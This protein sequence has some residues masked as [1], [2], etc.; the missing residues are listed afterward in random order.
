MYDEEE[1]R[2]MV[3]IAG[4]EALKTGLVAR[5]WGNISARI[6]KDEFVITP[7]GR[8]YEDLSPSDLVKVR[9]D[10][11]SY[12]GADK[13]SSEKG[14]H[15]ACYKLRG[16]VDFV[17]HTHQ[18]YA[19]AVGVT[20]KSIRKPLIPCAAY[21]MPSTKKLRNN[22]AKVVARY[23]DCNAFLM[24]KHGALCLGRTYEEAFATAGRL[25][26]VC[27]RRYFAK[28]DRTL[29]NTL[30]YRP[31]GDII[32]A[33]EGNEVILV[34]SLGRTLHPAI[35]DL[36]QITGLS[37][38]CVLPEA[39]EAEKQKALR[40]GCALLI[41]GE[42]ALTVGEDRDAVAQVLRK[43]CAAALYKG[44]LKGMNPADAFIQHAVYTLKYS[45]KKKRV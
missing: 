39:P 4:Q 10:D 43:G 6:S 12:E 32:D 37:V 8:A 22:V 16:D 40:G 26:E 38:R 25:E 23:P 19:T 9:I 2:R 11:C 1:A 14:I 34:S 18:F 29:A 3:V 5:T 17:I 45:K 31:R 27:R 41:K 15:A 20:G 42:G 21:G 28:L 36:A 44:N 7:S 30:S 13:P 24:E 33:V 35:D